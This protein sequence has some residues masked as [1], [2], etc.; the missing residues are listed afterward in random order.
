MQT[1]RRFTQK[2]FFSE[3]NS[4]KNKLIKNYLYLTVDYFMLKNQLSLTVFYL[5]FVQRNL[6][7][8]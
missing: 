7:H 6:Q 1:Q 4:S 5:K 3:V 8:F 2:V